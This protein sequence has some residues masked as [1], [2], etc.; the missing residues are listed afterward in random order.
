MWGINKLYS[1]IIDYT[2]FL[3]KMCI[4]IMWNCVK[5]FF[6]NATDET[7]GFHVLFHT[8]QLIS[9]LTKSI[10]DQI[11][12][13]GHVEFFLLTTTFRLSDSTS[14]TTFSNINKQH[15]N[16][17]IIRLSWYIFAF[18]GRLGRTLET[19]QRKWLWEGPR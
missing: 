18:C 7:A 6:A 8:I 2:V 4:K 1:H 9:Q 11:W 19:N 15:T 17:R 10:N 14:F 3:C 12:K 13:S 5:V 16:Y